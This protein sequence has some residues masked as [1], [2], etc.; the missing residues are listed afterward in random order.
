MIKIITLI[1]VSI[2]YFG[3]LFTTLAMTVVPYWYSVFALPGLS[4][5]FIFWLIP[6]V[7]FWFRKQLSTQ[8]L[9]IIF[10]INSIAL[11]SFFIFTE[12][13][14]AIEIRQAPEIKA[15]ERAKMKEEMIKSQESSSW[16][17]QNS[18]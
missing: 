1:V 9:K 11:V 14:Y 10:W 15:N 17:I 3:I 2:L 8:N 18:K 12:T 7:Y 13:P 6:I 16:N 4:L 5:Y